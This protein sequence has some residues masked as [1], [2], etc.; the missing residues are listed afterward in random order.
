MNLRHDFKQFF[1]KFYASCKQEILVIVGGAK[2]RG[3]DME[4][5]IPTV[6]SMNWMFK[7]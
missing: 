7:W 5:F 6:M 1:L 4:M 2:K 3:M